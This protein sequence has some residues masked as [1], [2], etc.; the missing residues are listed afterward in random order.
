MAEAIIPPWVRPESPET[1]R[2]IDDATQ[3]FPPAFGRGTTQR[4]IWADPRWG[5]RRRYR[6][7]RSDEK[8]AILNALSDTR[9]QF[10][11]LRVT[12]HTPLRGSFATSELL[13]NNSFA[14][15]TT[16]W[17]TGGGAV[18]TVSDRVSR[19]TYGQASTDPR[20][21]QS[22]IAVT[23]YAP[24]VARGFFVDG[25][26]GVIGAVRTND[27]VLTGTATGTTGMV[28]RAAVMLAS[29][30][31]VEFIDRKD[32]SG[33]MAGQS[34]FLPYTSFA[35]C[36][37]VDNGA[38]YLLQSDA[39]GNGAIWSGVTGL[40]TITDNA[41]TDPIGTT[42]AET[43]VENSS[44]SEHFIAQGITVASDAADFAFACAIKAGNR[45]FAALTLVEL[46]GSTSS[47]AFFNLSTGAVGTTGTGVNWSN[48]RSFIVALGNSWYYCCLIGRKTNAATGLSCRV[49][50]AS[51]NGTA[52]Y[53]GNGSGSI[54]AWRA[55]VAQSSVPMRLTATTASAVSSGTAQTGNRI[56][57]KGWPASTSGLLLTGDWIEMDGELKQLTAS[58][59]S[60]A[61]G[62]AAIQFRP[63]LAD[64]PADN[65]PVIVQEPFGRFIYPQGTR[66]L[67][68]LFGIYGDCEMNLEEVYV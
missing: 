64:S 57:T 52:T 37:L 2:W 50:I 63:G 29:T 55:T 43:L 66:E 51:A 67:E 68:N 33:N 20:I 11:V 14:S 58:V 59:N 22:S 24:Y 9:G 15:G 46:T 34:F 65:D 5:L 8:A 54:H 44:N 10:N 17:S 41:Q 38:N 45:S 13:T 39:L 61:S 16:G 1:I 62:R 49:Q 12:P 7:L 30:T 60:D 48:V 25:D 42:T 19:V 32:S 21:L 53:T 36:A 47:Q 3:G 6:G 4:G 31:T 27:G 28:T 35:R 56:Y 18:H 26:C 40:S 23:Q